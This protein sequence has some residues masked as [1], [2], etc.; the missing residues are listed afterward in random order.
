MIAKNSQ[1]GPIITKKF[2]LT[3][4]L[5]ASIADFTEETCVEDLRSFGRQEWLGDPEW[6]RAQVRQQRLFAAAISRPDIVSKLLRAYA[7][8]A[9][10]GD[11]LDKV[12]EIGEDQEILASAMEALPESDRKY[13]Q[14]RV[15]KGLFPDASEHISRRFTASI[16]RANLTDLGSGET[17]EGKGNCGG[18]G[19]T[20]AAVGRS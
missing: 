15:K 4:D 8:L 3:V 17:I 9:V 10:S 20:T 7:L 14:G 19:L 2:R 11:A 6:R 12:F 5:E 18:G 16:T 13:W 1:A